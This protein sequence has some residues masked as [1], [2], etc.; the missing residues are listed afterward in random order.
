M[1]ALFACAVFSI[2]FAAEAS[3]QMTQAMR[4]FIVAE[5]NRLRTAAIG[6]G[7]PDVVSSWTATAMME[8]EY[9]MKLECVAQAYVETVDD[10]RSFRHNP[11]RTADYAA[12]GGS[13]YVGE[14]WYS[15]APHDAITGGATRGWVDFRWPVAWGGN[16][17][18]ERENYHGECSGVTGHYT[19]VLW[20]NTYK[21]GCGYDPIGGTLC[22]YSPGG[23]YIGQ[24]P[25]EVGLACSACPTTHPFCVDGLCSKESSNDSTLVLRKETVPDGVDQSFT[26]TGDATGVIRDFS[27]YE[28]E[29][30]VNGQPG[31]YE[32]AETVPAGWALSDISCTGQTNS[33]VRLGSGGDFSSPG[34]DVGDTQVQVELEAGETVVCTFENM[35]LGSI[36]IV[37]SVAGSDVSLDFSASFAAADFQLSDGQS[38]EDGDDLY[39]GRYTVT[40]TV[41]EGYDLT[42]ISCTGQVNSAVT[43]GADGVQIDLTDGEDITCTFT[44]TEYGSIAVEKQTHPDG[45]AQVF[46]FTGN[47]SGAIADGGMIM[48]G[49]LLPG[50]YTSTELEVAGWDVSAITCDDADSSGDVAA[51]T[52]NFIVDAGEDVTCTFTNVQMIFSD[53]FE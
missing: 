37:N 20:A 6:P 45:S 5:H 8:I 41:P 40:E 2:V 22:N 25:F 47:A 16:G 53:G 21:V 32:S 13:G 49:N 26:F 24:S 43:E 52:A 15:G 1:K 3:A 48:V 17:C 34:F 9:D 27:T 35:L 23:N 38:Y 14:N 19:Q 10:P 50:N 4:D 44:N 31:T 18:S 30:S 29:L 11:N 39:S 12:C 7:G 28:E 46:E 51:A 42:D 33:Q 36:T